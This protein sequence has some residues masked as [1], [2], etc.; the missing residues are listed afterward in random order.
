MQIIRDLAASAIAD[1]ELHRLVSDVFLRVSDCPETL[2]FVLVVEPGDT[3]ASIDAILRFSVLANR[4]EFILEHADWYELVYVLG[5]DGFGLVVFVPKSI[6]LPE[7]LAMCVE[8]AL[9]A[10]PTLPAEPTP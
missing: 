8:Q 5:Q 3:I 1:P 9:P 4:H 6:C 2:G 10:V 7:L